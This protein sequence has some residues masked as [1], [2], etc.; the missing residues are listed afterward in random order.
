MNYYCLIITFISIVGVHDKCISQTIYNTGDIEIFPVSAVT[1]QI[2]ENSVF[3]SRTDPNIIITANNSQDQTAAAGLQNNL[4][5]ATSNDQGANWSGSFFYQSDALADPYCSIDL[6][7][8]MYVSYLKNS[9]TNEIRIRYSDDDGISWSQPILV[10]QSTDIDKPF[11]FIDTRRNNQSDMMLCAYKN[12]SNQHIYITKSTNRGLSWSTSI[13]LV[14]P[15]IGGVHHM[16]PNIAI[17]PEGNLYCVWAIYDVFTQTIRDETAIGISR[18]TDG[19]LTWTSHRVNY[20]DGTA[21]SDLPIKGIRTDSPF[22]NKAG[23]RHPSF[24]SVSVNQQNGN[25]YIAW[26]NRGLPP[27]TGNNTGDFD[28]C[29]IRSTDL[30]DTWNDATQ[31][32]VDNTTGLDQWMPYLSCDPF[33]GVLSIVYYNSRD[34]PSNDYINTYIAIS[35]DEGSTWI[36]GKISDN[37]T[38]SLTDGSHYLAHDYNGNDMCNGLVTPI[39]SDRRNGIQTTYIQPFYLECSSNLTLCNPVTPYYKIEKASDYIHVANSCNYEIIANSDIRMVAGQYIKFEP[40]FHSSNGSKFHAS[41][42]SCNP[43]FVN[44]ISNLDSHATSGKTEN[45]IS[46][47]FIKSIVSCFPNPTGGDFVIKIENENKSKIS[48]DL[49]NS[50]G[51]MITKIIDNYTIKSMKSLSFYFNALDMGIQS[52]SYN[53]RIMLDDEIIMSKLFIIKK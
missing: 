17:G 38:M 11:L 16:A 50:E 6:Q 37:L 51:R 36:N 46:S 33:N 10:A 19:G 4:Y 24:P 21:Y 49:I 23:S 31:V 22:N 53:L 29:F 7:G 14:T 41:I 18:S 5:V 44:R 39:W 12:Y 3:V 20:F 32:Y 47:E 42:S 30:G 2:S 28:I 8:R 48:I 25:L 45:N 1:S 40:G 13:D 26:V 34:F 35:Y 52:G 27:P 15:N 43:E 9:P